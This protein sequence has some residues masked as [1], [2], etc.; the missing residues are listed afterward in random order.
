M[1]ALDPRKIV[2]EV[3]ARHGIKIDAKDPMMAVVTLIELALM[4]FITPAVERIKAAGDQFEEAYIKTQRR[5]G[6]ALVDETR[7]AVAFLR[8]E[9]RGDIK[10]ARLHASELVLEVHRANKRGIVLR[11][12]GV[13]L[14]C[15]LM[16]FVL[17]FWTGRTP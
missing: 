2:A 6:E 13:S 15:A 9:I 14:I 16:L 17:G 5:A 3:A 11:W 10:N 7:R 8:A 1:D 4:Q 12:V